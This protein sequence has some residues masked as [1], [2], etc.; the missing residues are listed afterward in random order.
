VTKQGSRRD[1]ERP[2]VSVVVPVYNAVGTVSRTLR[3]LE[4]QTLPSHEFEVIMV[5]GNSTDGTQELLQAAGPGVKVLHNPLR[6][7]ASSRNLGVAMARGDVI[8][9]TDADCEPEPGW[10]AAGLKAAAD[11]PIVQG[12]VTPRERQGPF[13][14]SLWVTREY[15]LYETANLFVRREVFERVGGFQPVP[16]LALR[17]GAHFGEDVWF[18]WRAKR[19]GVNTAFAE[20]AAVHHAVFPRPI[21]AA[22][23]EA[24]RRRYFPH[25]VRLVP[26]LRHAFLHR[27]W[28]LNKSTMRFDLALVGA[29]L[30]AAGLEPALMLAA[31]YVKDRLAADLGDDTAAAGLRVATGRFAEDAVGFAALVAGSVAAGTLV[32]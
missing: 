32:I 16:G 18:V 3:A 8:A 30:A 14:R 10:L 26:E 15:G 6:D 28:F 21:S 12:R 19:L 20:A 29:I 24:S 25:L 31:P 13:D 23:A 1:P 11:V 17:D 5:D 22:L 9:F 4:R 7:P 2:A 27:R